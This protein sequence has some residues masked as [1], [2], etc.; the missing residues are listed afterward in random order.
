[1][2]WVTVVLCFCASSCLE[3]SVLDLICLGICYHMS[4]MRIQM[5]EE[6]M[7]R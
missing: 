6:I 1:L 3:Y 4:G 7:E 2:P 5:R